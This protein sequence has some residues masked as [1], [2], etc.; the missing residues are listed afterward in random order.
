MDGE[1]AKRG[2]DTSVSLPGGPGI[3]FFVIGDLIIFGVY[4]VCYMAYRGGDHETFLRSQQHL[5]QGIGV[6][7]T[8]ILL[9]SSLFVALGTADVRDGR[10]SNARRC[11]GMAAAIGALFPLL[12]M[13]EWVPDV[14]AGLTAGT[15]LFFMFYY[16]MTGLHLVHVLVG[17]T[18][19][20]FVMRGLGTPAQLPIKSVE[21]AGLYWHM[22]D[23]LWLV[24]FAIFYLMR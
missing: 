2:S 8:V 16:V 15:N 3:W 7:N 23:V 13:F 10:V 5:D 21:T 14:S 11:F 4:F 19:M 17:L 9:T 24:L 12:K 22:V 18:L 20:G 1:V 6:V